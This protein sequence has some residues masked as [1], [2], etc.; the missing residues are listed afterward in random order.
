MVAAKVVKHP[1]IAPCN[2]LLVRFS[3]IHA[4]VFHTIPERIHNA[5]AKVGNSSWGRG[6]YRG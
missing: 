4:Q 6:G 1:C 3:T 2:P 5:E